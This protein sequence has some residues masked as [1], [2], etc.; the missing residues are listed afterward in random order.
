MDRYNKDTVTRFRENARRKTQEHRNSIQ[1]VKAID[2]LY[3]AIKRG[4]LHD[5]SVD[6]H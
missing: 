6:R 3:D 5:P 4:V 1:A 2:A